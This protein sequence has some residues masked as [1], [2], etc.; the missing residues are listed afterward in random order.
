MPIEGAVLFKLRIGPIPVRPITARS[1]S[2]RRFDIRKEK[3]R[4]MSVVCWSW[5]WRDADQ[6]ESWK[7]L[8]MCRMHLLKVI[9]DTTICQEW[10]QM[11]SEIE[12]PNY[13]YVELDMLNLHRGQRFVNKP[14]RGFRQAERK[15]RTKQ[16]VSYGNRWRNWWVFLEENLN[17]NTKTKAKSDMKVI[18]DFFTSIGEER[19]PGQ[20]PPQG[21]WQY[22]G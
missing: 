7:T 9:L 12:S 17:K 3:S 2:G 13:E 21:H 15:C 6:T 19:A 1:E 11:I 4:E 5:K 14:E 8:K 10:K 20:I 18:T 22:Y 16:K